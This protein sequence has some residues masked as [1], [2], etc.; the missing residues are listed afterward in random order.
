MLKQRKLL[1]ILK[2]L[3]ELLLLES[4]QHRLLSKDSTGDDPDSVV[5]SPAYSFGFLLA[6]LVQIVLRVTKLRMI[7]MSWEMT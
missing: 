1:L 7:Q 5:E 3:C 6:S 4:F 2:Y